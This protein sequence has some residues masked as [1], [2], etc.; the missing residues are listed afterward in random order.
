MQRV[1]FQVEW[2]LGE[3]DRRA[4]RSADGQRIEKQASGKAAA[5]QQIGQKRSRRRRRRPCEPSERHHFSEN[6]RGAPAFN[7]MTKAEKAN[8]SPMAAP[9][10]ETPPA[11]TISACTSASSATV[12][13]IRA[14]V[15]RAYAR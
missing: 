6:T 3:G 1:G 15:R 7:D 12:A 10:R 13:R 14:I 11:R 4:E 8:T 2:R 5:P 9:T